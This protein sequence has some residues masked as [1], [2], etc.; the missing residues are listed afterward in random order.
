[1]TF[2]SRVGDLFFNPRGVL[3][4]K[5]W[6]LGFGCIAVVI[7][8]VTAVSTIVALDMLSEVTAKNMIAF[9]RFANWLHLCIFL[10]VAY[11]FYVISIK[12]R[13]DRGSTGWDLE[14]CLLMNLVLVVALAVGNQW[15]I[16]VGGVGFVWK[17]HPGISMLIVPRPT[18]ALQYFSYIVTAFSFVMYVLLGFLRSRD[19]EHFRTAHPGEFSTP[20]HAVV[21]WIWQSLSY[22]RAA[23][24]VVV[25]VVAIGV[26]TFVSWLQTSDEIA[27]GKPLP[28]A[29]DALMETTLSGRE[30]SA[31]PLKVRL[32]ATVRAP[33]RGHCR[34]FQVSGAVPTVAVACKHKGEWITTFALISNDQ[35][36][37]EQGLKAHLKEIRATIAFSEEGERLVFDL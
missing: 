33:K 18:P 29:I 7:A 3:S 25:I 10:L 34:S 30:A 1:V 32:T 28:P 24:G 16:N 11:P 23:M 21:H 4:R 26:T 8:V 19:S 37:R 12:R 6:W 36:E 9:Y 35:R 27:V 14:L 2:L 13:Y 5:G 20:G 22:R 17:E 31:G 15:V